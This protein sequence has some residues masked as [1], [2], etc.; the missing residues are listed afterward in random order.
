MWVNFYWIELWMK[1]NMHEREE[2]RSSKHLMFLQMWH[3]RPVWSFII[4]LIFLNWSIFPLYFQET[5]TRKL[6][7]KKQ[8]FHQTWA[9]KEPRL[10]IIKILI[11]APNWNHKKA[12]RGRGAW[13][14]E[15]LWYKNC[16]CLSVDFI[17][18]FYTPALTQ[19]IITASRQL[20]PGHL[21]PDKF[22]AMELVFLGSCPPWNL[23]GRK[24]YGLQL[25]CSVTETYSPT[26]RAHRSLSTDIYSPNV[27]SLYPIQAYI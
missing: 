26:L 21:P 2:I 18:F 23:S 9:P 4:K 14:S 27:G 17:H 13:F 19:H 3:Q 15:L 10:V 16:A 22:H 8:G 6:K 25:V 1:E 20:F 7:N 11:H 24:L 5:C 12:T